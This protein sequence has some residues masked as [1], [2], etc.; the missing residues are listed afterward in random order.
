MQVQVQVAASN[1][2][3]WGGWSQSA[4]AETLP[5]APTLAF[6]QVVR[7]TEVE[8]KWTPPAG[9]R[10]QYQILPLLYDNGMYRAQA[11]V[12]KDGGETLDSHL[13][14][15]L[16]KGRTYKFRVA[17]LAGGEQ[18]GIGDFSADSNAITMLST[19]PSEGPAVEPDLTPSNPAHKSVTA[20]SI[21]LRWNPFVQW[22]QSGGAVIR[23]FI[24]EAL[25]EGCEEGA[26]APVA[27]ADAAAACTP[28][29]S[30]SR[31]LDAKWAMIQPLAGTEGN[32]PPP[33]APVDW[34]SF[35]FTGLEANTKYRFRLRSQNDVGIGPPGPT[36]DELLTLPPPLPP[37]RLIASP[38]SI[39]LTWPPGDYDAFELRIA[40]RLPL[41]YAYSDWTTILAGKGESSL[42]V[43]NLKP[44]TEYKASMAARNSGG[45]GAHGAEQKGRTTLLA[46]PLLRPPSE[47]SNLLPTS[48]RLNWIERPFEELPSSLGYTVYACTV[49]DDEGVEL[50]PAARPCAVPD[51][52]LSA[53]GGDEF[54]EARAHVCDNTATSYTRTGLRK[55]TRYTLRLAN[56][57]PGGP[58]PLGPQTEIFKTRTSHPDKMP[59]PSGQTVS[60]SIIASQ[61]APVIDW[62]ARGG[63]DMIAYFISYRPAGGSYTKPLAIYPMDPSDPAETK[64]TFTGLQPNTVYYF[65]VFGENTACTLLEQSSL[66]ICCALHECSEPSDDSL[67]VSTLLPAMPAPFLSAATET[68]LQVAWPPVPGTPGNLVS[69][70]V[71]Y[72]DADRP[73]KDASDV[74]LRAHVDGAKTSVWIEGL[75]PNNRYLVRLRG[76]DASGRQ[77]PYGSSELLVTRPLALAPPRIVAVEATSVSIEWDAPRGRAA[78]IVGYNISINLHLDPTPLNPMAR[79]VTTFVVVSGDGRLLSYRPSGLMR[80]SAYSF[81]ISP[82]NAA[83]DAKR[84]NA[85]EYVRTLLQDALASCSLYPVIDAAAPPPVAPAIQGDL[86]LFRASR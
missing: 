67:P 44:D 59:A 23:K 29:W 69:V 31:E 19:A 53:C 57:N 33:S 79:T 43:S 12:I 17:V 15:P 80:D 42:L 47:I 37:P 7:A 77:S 65:R 54:P 39:V 56:V 26:A 76:T 70:L 24:V 11:P 14:A 36:S 71:E 5:L 64:Y 66:P 84:S 13:V 73:S 8:L 25:Q 78:N 50:L 58:G 74:W 63:L 48:A 85:T 86:F 4:I 34:Q 21:R 51:E 46:P 40:N 62:N 81:G 35:A 32:T 38:D 52:Q 16:L 82:T 28:G 68:M 18:T 41:Q 30:L 83:G 72:Q 1:N 3:G 45:W 61:W 60:M 9:A 22:Q 2:A 6:I 55:N 75:R 20:T 10:Q 27:D 49:D